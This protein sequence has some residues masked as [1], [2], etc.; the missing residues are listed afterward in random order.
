MHGLIV[1]CVYGIYDKKYHPVLEFD[2]PCFVNADSFDHCKP[3]V[4][5][6]WTCQALME[7][8]FVLEFQLNFSNSW[9]IFYKRSDL[10]EL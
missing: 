10:G 1:G 7:E 2:V 5:V 9:T 4:E 8:Y 6:I 3:L